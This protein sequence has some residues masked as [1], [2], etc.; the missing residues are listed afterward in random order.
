[1][2][3]VLRNVV[4]HSWVLTQRLNENDESYPRISRF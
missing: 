4:V 2:P 1:V 3:R